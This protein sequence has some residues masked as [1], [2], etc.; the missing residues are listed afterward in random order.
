[1]EQAQELATK[2]LW[3]YNHERPHSAI[4][5]IPSVKLLAQMSVATE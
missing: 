1:M 4:G 3:S 5:G 2:W